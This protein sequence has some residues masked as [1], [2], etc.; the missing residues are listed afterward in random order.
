MEICRNICLLLVA[1]SLLL[2]QSELH[3][4]CLPQ[5]TPTPPASPLATLQ[6]TADDVG[7]PLDLPLKMFPGDEKNYEAYKASYLDIEKDTQKR[8]ANLKS[9]TLERLVA[10]EKKLRANAASIPSADLALAASKELMTD[11]F[12]TFGFPSTTDDALKKLQNVWSE[13]YKKLLSKRNRNVKK[14]SQKYVNTVSRLIKDSKKSGASVKEIELLVNYRQLISARCDEKSLEGSFVLYTDSGETP[15]LFCGGKTV[16]LGSDGLSQPFRLDLMDDYLF[17]EFSPKSKKTSVFLS[18]VSTDRELQ[19]AFAPED[20]RG[21]VGMDKGRGA[22]FLKILT[23]SEQPPKGEP[24]VLG[25]R[26]VESLKL[27]ER[28]GR[29]FQVNPQ[30][31]SVLGIKLEPKMLRSVHGHLTRKSI[32]K[33][34]MTG[35]DVLKPA[36][37]KK[38]LV[39]HVGANGWKQLVEKF[40]TQGFA[41]DNTT[42]YDPAQKDYSKYHTIVLAENSLRKFGDQPISS[43]LLAFVEQGGHLLSLGTYNGGKANAV[44]KPFGIKVGFQ[45]NHS[46]EEAGVASALLFLGNEDSIPADKHLS[47]TGSIACDA[48]HTVVLKRGPGAKAGSAKMLTMNVG[49]GRFTYTQVQPA[50][51][52]GSWFLTSLASWISRGSPAPPNQ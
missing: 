11:D 6:N 38:M 22:D 21:L 18:F 15:K 42:K 30:I 45:H 49:Q 20:F 28:Q 16:Q 27:I 7:P 9:S 25:R 23:A 32:P 8:I 37:D 40:E 48:K 12:V 3:G 5:Q 43:H 1:A 4:K 50:Y 39:L 36:P 24:S 10:L 19:V 14:I 31:V 26:K 2:S 17:L 52:N 46:F 35:F 13:G 33:I 44:L 34:D 41:V 51:R 29:W 47:S